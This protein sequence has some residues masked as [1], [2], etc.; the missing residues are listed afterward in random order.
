MLDGIIDRGSLLFFHWLFKRIIKDDPIPGGEELKTLHGAFVRLDAACS[1][2]EPWSAEDMEVV[3][4]WIASDEARL[5]RAF[6]KAVRFFREEK[7]ISRLALSKKCRVSLR[8]ILAL[9][10]GRGFDF[11]VPAFVRMSQALGVELR[12]LANKVAQFEKNA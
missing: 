9:E 12:E 5:C 11:S 6:G 10:R 3:C 4:K 1:N 8:F 2:N 7:R